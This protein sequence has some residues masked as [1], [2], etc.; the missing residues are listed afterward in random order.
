MTPGKILVIGGGLGGLCLAQGLHRAGLEVAVFEKDHDP[1]GR[2]Q[3]YRIHINPEGSRALYRCLPPPAWERFVAAAG[4][5]PQFGFFTERLECLLTLDLSPRSAAV[6]SRHNSISRILLKQV[7]LHGM[8]GM[9]HF[10]K[11]FR[12]YEIGRGGR[13]LARFEDGSAAEGDLL[14]A[15]DGNH[16][17]VRGQ[18][19]PNAQRRDTGAGAIVGQAILDEATQRSFDPEF[20]KGSGLVLAPRG[21]SMFFAPHRFGGREEAA[22]HLLWAFISRTERRGFP[23]DPAG[24]D[25]PALKDAALQQIR[26]WHPAF[27]RMV[28]VSQATSISFRQIRASSRVKPWPASRVTLL[29]DA[30]HSMTPYR[31]IGAS[32]ALKDAAVLCGQLES[33]A[34]GGKS[35][36]EAI[37]AYEAEMRGYGFR[38]VEKSAGA[39]R[40]A[41]GGA[42]GLACTRTFLRTARS[43]PWLAQKFF[44]EIA[45]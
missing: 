21:G 42:L 40:H 3:A 31:G 30:I 11:A 43:F 29:G 14:V 34:A 22:D 8:D 16:S 35:V 10:D 6:E 45:G 33:A 17:R 28:S 5:D 36:V 24:M 7:L 15:A 12:R 2:P 13:I 23:A 9:V 20:L 18:Y 41:T 37:A 25:G 26:T 4:V 1:A 44:S 39:L 38:A 32:A 27:S 19:L